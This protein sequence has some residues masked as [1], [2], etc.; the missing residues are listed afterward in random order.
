MTNWESLIAG[1]MRPAATV[2]AVSYQAQVRKPKDRRYYER[3]KY[4]PEFKRKKRE[5][6][7]KYRDTD[8]YR[9]RHRIEMRLWRAKKKQEK[10]A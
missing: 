2:S 1:R 7:R 9:E 4:D 5:Q 6:M 10:T 8:S 3:V